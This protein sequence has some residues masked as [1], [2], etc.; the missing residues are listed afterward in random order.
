MLPAGGVIKIKGGAGR[1]LG[2]HMSDGAIF[3]EKECDVRPG[4]CMTGGK[5]VIAGTV[6]EVLPPSPSTA[7]NLKSKST[8]PNRGWTILRVPRRLG[9][10]WH[11]QNLCLQS[12]QSAI[13]SSTKNTS[14]ISLMSVGAFG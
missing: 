9:R 12:K 3:V 1:F 2:Y 13:E 4:A 10:A 14:K 11:R 7:L 6:E 5:I 8:T